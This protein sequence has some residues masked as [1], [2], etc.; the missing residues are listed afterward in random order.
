MG[1]H[2]AADNMGLR[3]LQLSLKIENSWHEKIV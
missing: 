1:L 2:F 3:L